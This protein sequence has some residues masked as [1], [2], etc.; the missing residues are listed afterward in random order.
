[1]RRASGEELLRNGMAW[2]DL[3]FGFGTTTIEIKSGYGLDLETERKMLQVLKQMDETHPVDVVPTFLV[4]AVPKDADR[5]KYLDLVENAMIPEFREYASWF[6]LFLEKDVFDL[7]EA[8]RLLRKAKDAG[9]QLGLHANQVFDIKGISLAVDVGARHVDHLEVLSP[10]DAALIV[11]T[12]GLYAV[13]LPSAEIHAFSKKTGRIDRLMDMPGRL[14]L[15]T[16][17]NPG[18]SP[19]LSPAAVMAMA[20]WRY[21]LHDPRL[22]VEAFTRNPAD[23]LFLHDRGRIETGARADLVLFA[24]D[25]ASQIPYYGTICPAACVVKNGVRYQ[26]GKPNEI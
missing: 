22:I 13:F 9:Y 24:L 25:Q 19:V 1:V 12:A 21:R 8:E 20:V 11:R 16:N 17:F 26:I 14:V 18:T 5:R 2:L 6:D 10:G 7:P 23:M 4:H 15:S 3:A